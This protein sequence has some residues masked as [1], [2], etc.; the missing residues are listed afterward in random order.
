V[1]ARALATDPTVLVL[2]TPTAGVDVRSKQT[3]LEVVRA[4]ADRGTAVLVVSDELDDLRDCD[5]VHVMLQGGMHA[6]YE[7]GWDDRELVAAMEG[8]D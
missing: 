8:L 5:R 1:F 7:K 6:E 4:A 3:L 2:I